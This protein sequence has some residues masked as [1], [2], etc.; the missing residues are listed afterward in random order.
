MTKFPEPP[1]PVD[2]TRSLIE[3][4]TMDPPGNE[5]V[6]ADF[7]GG[8]LAAAGLRVAYHTLAD[9][10][11]G[12]VA[13]LPGEGDRPAL[14]FCGHL[15]TVPAGGAAWQGHPLEARFSQGKIIGRGASDMKS[16]LAA[17]TTAI[18]RL[19]AVPRRQADVV[20]IFTAGEETGSEGASRMV[21][22][23]VLPSPA[24]ALI[25]GEPSG[26]V[27]FLGHK[28]TLWL[29]CRV[30]GKSAHGSMPD[31]GKN[32]VIAAARAILALE[33]L[34]DEVAADPRLGRPTLNV[35]TFN[36][37]TKINMVPDLA[38]FTVDMRTV[39]GL[40]HEW[41]YRRVCDRLGPALETLKL[42][43]LPP[44][45]TDE[46][47]PW[48]REV[49]QLLEA[50]DFPARPGYVNYFTDASTL[51]PGL[52]N[53]PVLILGPGEA[54]QAHQTD[55]WCRVDDIHRAAE[56]YLHIARAWCRV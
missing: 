4:D 27:P 53:P 16:G 35:G 7:L 36:G 25:L 46:N 9:G 14:C 28:G 41:L 12:L 33:G 13:T 8:I 43:D 32:A 34:L 40:S 22:D 3:L 51:A 54:T 44:V 6:A 18:L 26:N 47:E 55:E 49:L 42:L 31:Q 20:A 11:R 45:L 17:M 38:E 1:D 50:A 52:G 24:G 29:Q 19:A 39:P 30:R 48:I 56:I 37:G 23:G 15:D 10:R 21:T 2:L 5:S